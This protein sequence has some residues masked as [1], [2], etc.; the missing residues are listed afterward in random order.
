MPNDHELQVQNENLEQFLNS[1]KKVR[2]THKQTRYFSGVTY[3]TENQLKKVLKNH[4]SSV[5]AF[6]YILHDKDEAEPHTHFI[7]RTHSTWYPSQVERW[8][9]GL[10][11]QK[12]QPVN[13]FCEPANDL[14]A[15]DQ[16][17]T[18]SD[19]ESISKG[20]HQYDR[21][22]IRDFGLR[23]IIPKGN[24]YDSSYEVIN[25]ILSGVSFRKL[26]I[27]YGRDFVYHWQSYCDLAQ[28]I[29]NQEGY[30]ESKMMAQV[31]NMG[32]TTI[33]PESMEQLSCNDVFEI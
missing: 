19:D 26:I 32:K 28:E 23:D 7:I 20:K 12:K 17:L 21:S 27:K 11:D 25:D 30:A 29:R 13:T 6:C 5:R 18:H 31:A 22:E 33:K 14:S 10:K 2:K 3:A 15:L 1:Q 9:S 16:Y 24:S 8:F 4:I